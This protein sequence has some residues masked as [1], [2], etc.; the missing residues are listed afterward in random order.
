MEKKEL[1]SQV[2]KI[3]LLYEDAIDINSSVCENDYLGYLDRIYVCWVGI[4]N[5][6]VY[7]IIKGLKSL[8]LEAEHQTVRSMVFHII[9]I[10]EKGWVNAV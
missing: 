9:N 3:L 8:G 10:I 2:Y 4:G 1:I 6:E 5:K 7:Y